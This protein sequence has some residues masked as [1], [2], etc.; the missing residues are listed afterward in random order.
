MKCSCSQRGRDPQVCGPCGTC[1][2]QLPIEDEP[3]WF[4]VRDNGRKL[5]QVD[6]E[7]ELDRRLT[8]RLPTIAEAQRIAA[9]VAKPP[10][11]SDPA[12]SKTV[13]SSWW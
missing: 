13:K 6:L 8:A 9:N 10:G 3:T 11:L 2:H 5:A 7:D 4:V 1:L 12:D